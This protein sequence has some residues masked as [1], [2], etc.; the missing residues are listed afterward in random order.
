MLTF[1]RSRSRSRMNF[2]ATTAKASLI[3]KTSI[4]S[5]VK[6]AFSNTFFAAGTGALSISVGQSPIFAVATM[7]AR[8]FMP[9]FLT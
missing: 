6:P 7:R 8:G 1:D 2:S 3:S 4:S 9:V 5:L